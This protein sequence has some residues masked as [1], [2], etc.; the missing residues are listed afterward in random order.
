MLKRVER[1]WADTPPPPTPSWR[2]NQEQHPERWNVR[3][4]LDEAG[5]NV[6]AVNI[7]PGG[8][9]HWHAIVA[10]RPLPGDGKNAITAALSVADMKHVTVVDHDI[11]I[12]DYYLICF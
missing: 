2:L 1:E 8:C 12:F 11:D 7:T 9:C 4:V 5:V 6:T 3:R 10:I